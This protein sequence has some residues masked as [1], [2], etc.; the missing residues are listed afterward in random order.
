MRAPVRLVRGGWPPTVERRLDRLFWDDP[1]ALARD[2]ASPEQFR[3]AM[4]TIHVGDT[5]KI[6]GSNRHP[7]ADDLLVDNL[8]L[9]GKTIVDIGASDGS[10]SVDLVNRLPDFGSYV[11]ADLFLTVSVLQRGIRMFVYGPDGECILIAGPRALAWPSLS[12]AVRGLYRPLL[13]RAERHRGERRELLLLNPAARELI[14]RDQRV[15]YRIHDVFTVW[16][17]ELPD[18]I[19][20]ANLL[21]RLYFTDAEIARAL[22]A[23]HASL[24]P[25]GHLLIVD[26]PRIAGIPARAGLY[27]RMPAGFAT[28]A[29]SEHV[30]EISDLIS[31]LVIGDQAVR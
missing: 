11:I 3:K 24:R 16:S 17:G 23:V 7:L 19:K 20:I 4:S 12:G 25:D 9:T 30:P 13:A 18:V 6:T 31:E 27:R 10:T 22:R 28:V 14:A 15:S 2:D 1:R 29:E 21:R 8:D 5:I 26:N